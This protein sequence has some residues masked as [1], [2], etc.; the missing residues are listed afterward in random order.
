MAEY[1]IVL[2]VNETLRTLKRMEPELYKQARKDVVKTADP[3]IKTARGRLMDQ[4]PKNW[5]GWRGGYSRGAASRGIR[6]QLK[7]ER[8]RGFDGRRM[9]FRVVQNNA[10]GAIYDNAGSRGNYSA[11]VQRGQNFVDKLTRQSGYS[12]Q[13]ALWPAAVK[14]RDDV[15]AAFR[16]SAF[17]M[18]DVISEELARRGYSRKGRELAIRTGYV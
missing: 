12:A 15:H 16:R 17:N 1:G 4:S 10:G 18:A 11:P 13:R 8:V 6:A 2:G 14:H 5:V 3:I 7:Q 9:I